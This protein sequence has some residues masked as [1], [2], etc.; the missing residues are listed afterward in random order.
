MDEI[1]DDPADAYGREVWWV[2]LLAVV[3]LFGLEV[4]YTRRLSGQEQ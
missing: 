4:W 2:I 3:G 1:T